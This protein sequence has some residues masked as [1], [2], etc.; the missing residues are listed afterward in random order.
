M[1]RNKKL[2]P[3]PPPPPHGLRRP[4]PPPNPPTPPPPLSQAATQP[5]PTPLKKTKGTVRLRVRLGER[6]RCPVT[7]SSNP[8]TTSPA[9]PT[10]AVSAPK[11]TNPPPPP[12]RHRPPPPDQH[13]HPQWCRE[14]GRPSRGSDRRDG[15]PRTLPHRGREGHLPWYPRTEVWCC[16]VGIPR[17][18]HPLRGGPAPPLPHP[19][20]GRAVRDEARSGKKKPKPPASTTEETNPPIP[21]P[22]TEPTNPTN[23]TNPPSG[24]AKMWDPTRGSH[25]VSGPA[26]GPNGP[27]W[28]C[29]TFMNTHVMHYVS[30]CAIVRRVNIW[31][32]EL[33]FVRLIL[34]LVT[35]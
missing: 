24:P 31:G 32:I 17:R 2:K 10:E 26:W 20:G 27:Q 8:P 30:C 22:T 19:R 14:E 15:H 28:P 6:R 11:P 35:F 12:D 5:P 23:S 29:T 13:Q 7:K 34:M 33:I 4:S 1:P 18:H 9:R 21:N 3:P 16:L 25:A